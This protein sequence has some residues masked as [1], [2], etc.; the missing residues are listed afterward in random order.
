M[1]FVLAFLKAR[2]LRSRDRF[3]RS[4]PKGAVCAE[5]GVWRG[6]FSRRILELTRPDRLH[7]IDPWLFQPSYPDR[8][9]G[10]QVA[11]SPQDMEE[12]YERV[13]RQ[14]GSHPSVTIHRT[15]SAAAADQFEDE[16]FDWIYI[17][18]NHDFAWV[19]GDL[20]RYAPKV[21]PG[22]L[23]TGDDWNWGEAD[24]FPIRRAVRTFLADSPGYSVEVM[25]GQFIVRKAAEAAKADAGPGDGTATD[26]RAGPAGELA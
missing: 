16:Y 8:M 17:D 2:D 5:I 1:R 21:K 18:G 3:L 19:L 11:R 23:I 10:G 15:T 6:E 22:G 14:L 25:K 7:L 12:I 24:G 20:R 13:V 26:S 9:Y 4:M